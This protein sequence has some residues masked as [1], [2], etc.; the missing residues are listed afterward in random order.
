M[1]NEAIIA[2]ARKI[3]GERA[4][5]IIRLLAEKIEVSDEDI[6]RELKL[7]PAEVRRILNELFESRLV[8]YRRARDEVIGWYKYYWR[9]TD[10]PVA[11]ILE[12][13]KRLTLSLL[14]KVLEYER[15]DEFFVCPKCGKRFSS[16]EADENGYMCDECREVL[17]PYDN[18]EVIRK[19]EQAIKKLREYNP[20]AL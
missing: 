11:R 18:T 9:I 7:D 5:I 6:A 1:S 14:E 19:L 2:L 4:E 8:K 3:H 15:S 10:E 12:D 16:A 13:R 20:E 17:E